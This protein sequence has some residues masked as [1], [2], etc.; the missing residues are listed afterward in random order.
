MLFA[1]ER[2]KPENGQAFGQPINAKMDKVLKKNGIDRA[3]QFRRIEGNGSRI[4]MEKCVAIID[5]MEAHVLAAPTRVAGT[6]NE[7]REVGMM[8]KHILTS[9]DGYFSALRTK[10]FHLTP[11]ILEKAKLYRDQVLALER[12]LGMSITTKIHLAEDQEDLDGIGDLGKDFGER[13]QQDEAKA[14]RRLGCVQKFAIKEWIKSKEEVQIKDEKVQA[15]IVAIR[16]KRKKGPSDANKVRQAA[17][18]QRQMDAR[19]KVLASPITVGKM[20]T[21]REQRV[22]QLKDA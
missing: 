6:D 5:E 11:E 3:A 14:D 9:L 19:A 15:K 2:K 18:K 8:H 16:K 17:K 22:L 1:M 7:I 13:N 20:V 10:R 21:L 12:Y 4:L